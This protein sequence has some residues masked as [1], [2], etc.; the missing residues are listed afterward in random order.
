MSNFINNKSLEYKKIR[1]IIHETIK[2]PSLELECLIGNRNYIR[3]NKKSDLINIIKRIKGKKPFS[4]FI[5]NDVLSISFGNDVDISRNISRVIINGNGNINRYCNTEKLSTVLSSANVEKKVH[6]KKMRNFTNN[7]YNIKFNLKEESTIDKSSASVQELVKK[8]HTLPKIYRRKKTYTFYHDS[9]DFKVDLSI[10]STHP[11]KTVTVGYVLENN[12]VNKVIMDEPKDANNFSDWWNTKKQNKDARVQIS[13]YVPHKTLKESHVL[14]NKEVLYEFEVEW[15]GNKKKIDLTKIDLDYQTEKFINIIELI[16][17]VIQSSFFIIPNNE[18]VKIMREFVNLANIKNARDFFPLAVDLKLENMIKKPY[19]EYGKAGS[20]NIRT[21]YLVTDKADGERTLLFISN[22]GKCYL[23]NRNNK[24]IYSGLKIDKYSQSIF[25]GE[26]IDKT[27]SG[28]TIQNLYLFDAYIINKKSILNLPFGNGTDKDKTGRHKYIVD[29]VNHFN[30]SDDVLVENDNYSL[31]LFRKKYLRSDFSGKNSDTMIFDSCK[32]ILSKVNVEYGGLL[33]TGHLYSYKC[34]GLIF[35]PMKLG[36][37]V[38]NINDI[39]KNNN[40]GGRWLANLKW[41][42]EKHITIDFKV[43]F[44]KDLNGL[45]KEIYDSVLG[46]KYTPATLY[47]KLYNNIES[48]K[49]LAFRL[50]NEGLDFR[51]LSEDFPFKPIDPFIETITQNGNLTD[52][53]GTIKLIIGNDGF[54]RCENRDIIED[55]TTIEARYEKGIMGSDDA[56]SDDV[57]SG[58]WIATRVRDGKTPNAIKS[59][60]DAW[61]LTFNNIT[62]EHITNSEKADELVNESSQIYYKGDEHYETESIK[63]YNN[64]VKSV[65]IDR[66]LSNKTEPRVMDIG[67]GKLGDLYKYIS[68]N[69]GA[70]V[71]IDLSSDNLYNPHDGAAVRVLALSRYQNQNELDVSHKMLIKKTMLLLGTATRNF[72]NG[73]AFSDNLSKY[74]ASILYGNHYVEDSSGKLRKMYNMGTNLFHAILCN[75][76]IHYMMNS[77][78]DFHNFCLNIQE[79]LMEQGY[80]AITFLDKNEIMKELKGKN[81]SSEGKTKNGSIVWSIKSNENKSSSKSHLNDTIKVYF[82]TFARE[83]DENLVD[84]K[85]LESRFKN[86]GLKLIDSKLFLEDLSEMVSSFKQK[87]KRT[88]KAWQE[89]ENEPA[90]KKWIGFHRWAIFQKVN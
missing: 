18:K 71:G 63:L 74:Y 16:L 31:S 2:D 90:F 87:S 48:K 28:K 39:K 44:H 76:S 57:S 65:I 78:D 19:E 66:I 54:I 56:D 33:E 32:K 5:V 38:N 67:C 35:T 88:L 15:I 30:S 29:I 23:I 75:F 84:I 70:L 51:T 40:I 64:H 41:K 85:F 4:N 47:I 62:T 53:V 42:P 1:E 3:K 22:N 68:N 55:G 46:A 60:F 12:I 11:Y 36:V 27:L 43:K 82:E 69:V 89:I 79:N 37:S 8:W 34:D 45:R 13:E 25:D 59:S 17:Q 52:N 14:E 20:I 50:L 81:K 6:S 9:G 72:A 77:E 83:T 10:V 58:R 80:F 26:F 61:H 21:D 49:Y 24:I 73:T 86:Y 7:D